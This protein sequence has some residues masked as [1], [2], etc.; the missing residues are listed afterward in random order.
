MIYHHLFQYTST[1]ASIPR[2]AGDTLM[3]TTSSFGKGVTKKIRKQSICASTF[4]S[5][6][7]D[8]VG[9]EDLINSITHL[10]K[11]DKCADKRRD[12]KI[13]HAPIDWSKNS[14]DGKQ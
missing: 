1:V 14:G 13:I 7:K 3:D 8:C 9:S 11:D 4:L 2:Q 10:N 12:Q 6:V 5:E